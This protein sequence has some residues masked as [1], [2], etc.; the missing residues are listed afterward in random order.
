MVQSAAPSFTFYV[1]ASIRKVKEFGQD[2][3][4]YMVHVLMLMDITVI[5]ATSRRAMEQNLALLMETTVALHMSCHP[6][7]SKL[8]TVNTSDTEPFII[9]DITILYTDSHV[10][11][12]SQT[13][14]AP[15]QKQV[16]DHMSLKKCHVSKFS[17]FLRKNSDVSYSINKLVWNSAMS[18]E[19]MYSCVSWWVR[20]LGACT[21]Y[22]G[23]IKELLG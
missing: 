1:N 3:F 22:M 19:V 17:S 14:N 5:F 4:L 8:I 15:M 6:V 23:S 2:G 13:S 7:Y 11:L 21:A 9:N 16:A 12:G 20:N 10:Y 18:S